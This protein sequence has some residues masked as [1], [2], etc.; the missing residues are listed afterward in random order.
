MTSYKHKLMLARQE[1]PKNL[2]DQFKSNGYIKV[3]NALS[4]ET[5]ELITQHI[6]KQK[7]WNLVF[8]HNGQHQDLNNL[9]VEQWNSKQKQDLQ[10]IIYQQAAQGFQYHYETI[11]LY[12]IYHDNLLPDHF[13][14]HIMEFL[15][16]DATLSY[17]RQLLSA[18]HI[19]FAD[20]QITRFR[21]GHFLNRHNDDV[22]SKNRIAAFVINLTKEWRVDWGGALHLL[23]SNQNITK[24]FAPSFNEINIFKIPVDHY[25]GYVSP[26]AAQDRISITGWLR[27]GKN[28][29]NKR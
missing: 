16:Q 15:N 7:Q 12:D 23:D 22:D 29:K 21:Q 3:P 25:V 20:G 6:T 5:A 24:S 10:S 17:F 11:P 2:V 9:E 8:D 14:N 27:S 13:F 4:N 1:P 18:P 28:P 26:F 19:S